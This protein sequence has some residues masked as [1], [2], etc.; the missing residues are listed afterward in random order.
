MS[1]VSP[2]IGFPAAATDLTGRVAIVTGAGSGIG[3]ATAE[4]LAAC[5]AYVMCA[6]ISPSVEEVARA[7]GPDKATAR[8][9]DVS[10]KADVDALIDAAVAKYGRLDIMVNSA[11]IIT[12]S[13]LLEMEEEDF[14]R[15]IAVDLKGVMFGCQAAARVMLGQGTGAIVNLASEAVDV[16][17]AL[18]VGYAMCKAAVVKL[19]HCLAAE[20]GKAGIRVNAV[21]PGFI[22][23]PMTGRHYTAADGTVDAAKRSTAI[24]AFTASNKLAHIGQPNDIAHAVLFLVSDAARYMTGQI[25]RPNGGGSM[26]W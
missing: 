21:S 12:T 2:E 15:L 5:G 8:I 20:V 14:D 13:P 24:G 23:S 26:P 22:E 17:A 1:G 9:V 6:D 18:V 4:L 3:R 7:I 11:G 16:P 10:R 19:T 25:L